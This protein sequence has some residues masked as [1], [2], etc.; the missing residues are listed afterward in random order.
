LEFGF[1]DS[2]NEH[3]VPSL[4]GWLAGQDTCWWLVVCI[5]LWWRHAGTKRY[6]P[7]RQRTVQSLHM[8]TTE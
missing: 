8:L 7:G 6:I 1:I 2:A 4:A 5:S 3:V